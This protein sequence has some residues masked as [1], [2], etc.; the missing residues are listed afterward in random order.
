VQLVT[1]ESTLIHSPWLGDVDRSPD[2][3]LYFPAGLPG[4][5]ALRRFLPVEIPA[6]RPLV[7][8]QSVENSDICFVTL[9]VLVID[10][11]F[12]L[13]LCEEEKNQLGISAES[14]P[15]IGEDVLCLA[16][17]MPAGETVEAN[18][19]AV[20]VV[21]LHNGFGIQCT[22]PFEE[23]AIRRLTLSGDAMPQNGWT[24]IC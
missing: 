10:S 7:Y 5:E 17:L 4:F 15:V 23:C 18:L 3:E 8:L 16:M 19:S 1:S 2:C 6:Q 22:P 24:R 11:S 14:T 21:N 20:V 9:P 12:D 13:K